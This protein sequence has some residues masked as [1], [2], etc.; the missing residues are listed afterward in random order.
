VTVTD[1]TIERIGVRVT[2]VVQGVGFRPFVHRLARRHALAGV[3]GNDVDGVFVEVEGRHADLDAFLAALRDEA[4]PLAVVNSISATPLVPTGDIAFRIVES[5]RDAAGERT[6]VPPDVA[7]CDDC[8]AEL[9]DLG[10]RRHRYPFANC[11]NCGP[12]FTIIRDLP[13]D[14]PVTTMAGFA[15]CDACRAEYDDPDDRRFHAQPVACPA[16]GPQL[17][18]VVDR[19]VTATGTDPVLAGLHAA[20]A[21]GRIAALKGI[22]GYHLACDARNEEAVDEL[23]RRKGRGDKPFAV[24]VC[25]LDHARRIAHVDDREAEALTSP[26]RP[27]VLLRR[28]DDTGLTDGLA[29]GNPLIGVML[30]YSPFHHLLFAPVP[31]TLTPPPDVLVLTSGNRSDEPI[32]ADDADALERL[33]DLV[34]LFVVHDRP[35][36]VPC[37]DSVVRIVDDRV[38]PLRRSRGYAPLP[39]ALPVDVVPTLAVGGEL[40]NTFCLA[41][42]RRAWVSQHV[43]DMENL[44]T[45]RSFQRGVDGFR[46]MYAIEPQRWAVDAHPGYLTRRWALHE[47]AAGRVVGGDV[48]DVQHHHAH[49]AAVMAEHGIGADRRVIGVAFDGTGAGVGDDGCPEIWGGEFLVAGYDGFVRAGH[50]RPWPLPGGDAAVRNPNRIAV[51]ALAAF[52]IARHPDLPCVAACDPIE[53]GLVERQVQRD[54]LST[55]TT[56]MGRLFD[57]VASL[58]GVRHR[59]GYEAQAAIELEVVAEHGHGDAAPAVGF[60]I[61][62]RG[63]VDPTPVLRAICEGVLAGVPVAVLALAFHHAV[64]QAVVAVVRH[65]RDRHPEVADAPVA[66]TG[67][68]FQNALLVRLTRTALE[69]DGAEVLTHRLVPPNDGGLSLGQAVIAGV[70]RRGGG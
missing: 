18:L 62:H 44:E 70:A 15:W 50:L 3:V 22:G 55:P 10:D 1:R 8:L 40:K 17:S 29:P 28:R 38:M 35:I 19:R 2:G 66:L 16:C 69:L 12:R 24:M 68:V 49:V 14:R 32:C 5:A 54:T 36:E 41:S 6:S 48:I 59:I 52:G 11:T 39:V 30:P 37:D 65:V 7:V 31:G 63:V 43:G 13:Y 20:L 57:A 23:R 51:A 47:V 33:G 34:D 58:L 21:D 45:L 42:G 46:R 27:I 56:S 26:A 53:L 25:S 60:A 67:G 4:P 61:D 9:F 64:A